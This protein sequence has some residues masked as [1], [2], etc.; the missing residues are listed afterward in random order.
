MYQ[1]SNPQTLVGTATASSRGAH[2]WVG[3]FVQMSRGLRG[4]QVA[5]IDGAVGLIVAPG[6]KVARVML[7]TVAA[8]KVARVEVLADPALLRGLEIAVL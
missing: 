5:L 2:A 6:G 3:R 7:F 8:D 4:V 1:T